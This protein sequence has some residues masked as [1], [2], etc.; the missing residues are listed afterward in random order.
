MLDNNNIY[1]VLVTNHLQNQLQSISHHLSQS[2]NKNQDIHL[3]PRVNNFASYK[4]FHHPF[5]GGIEK[6]LLVALNFDC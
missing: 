6:Q 5:Y 3:N 1:L 4:E 2:V